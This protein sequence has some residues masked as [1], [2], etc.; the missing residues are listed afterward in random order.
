[1]N[2][3]THRVTNS[4]MSQGIHTYL[5]DPESAMARLNDSCLGCMVVGGVLMEVLLRDASLQVA[6]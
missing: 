1:M 4:G 2:G 5:G 3:S 6:H